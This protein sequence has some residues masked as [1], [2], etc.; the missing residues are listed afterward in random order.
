MT[1][2]LLQWYRRHGRDLPWRKTKDPYRILVSEI[3]LQQTQV[4]RGLLYYE[5]WLKEFPDWAT[6]A[7][8]S[9]A[10]VIT[11]WAGLGYNRR[12]LVLRDIAR[13]VI[14]HGEPKTREEWLHFKGIGPYTSAALAVF[15]I[16]EK[17]LPIDTNIR[18]VLGRYFLGRLFPVLDDDL[19]INDIASKT[20]FKS[21]KYHDVPQ[22]LFDLAATH[23]T[24]TPDC[25]SC[26]LRTE[27]K[28]STA[29]LKGGVE[30]PKRSIRK[31]KEKVQAGKKYPDRIYRGRILKAVR[32]NGKLQSSLVGCLV[33]PNYTKEDKA[34]MNAMIQR[35]IKDGLLAKT[36]HHLHLP[37]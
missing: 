25:G 22:A 7:K 37:H 31:A 34:W 6:L 15:T 14:E 21:T 27:C 26:P 20:L 29:F 28:S 16:G 2:K 12:A 30:V 35:L 18:R 5:K 4:Q 3:M 9:N 32:E 17:V 23:C 36:K 33:D 24:K 11:A 10:Q 1:G 13:Q 19:K 8:A